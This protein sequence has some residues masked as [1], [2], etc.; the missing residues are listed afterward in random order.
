M[1][2]TEGVG[3]G[4]LKAGVQELKPGDVVMAS[5]AEAV[6]VRASQLGE[7]SLQYFAVFPEWL[8]GFLTAVEQ[9]SLKAAADS[10]RV[11]ARVLASDTPE[12]RQFAE[13]AAAGAAE[14]PLVR[15]CR[16]LEV[17]ARVLGEELSARPLPKTDEAGGTARFLRLVSRMPEA[18]LR[19]VSLAELA[20][21]CECSER[22]ISR[23][24]RN[25]FGRSV[26]ARQI[27]LRLQQAQ[28]LLR[29]TNAKVIDVALESGFGH[30]RLFNEKFKRQF[31]MTPSEWRAKSRQKPARRALRLTTTLV[32]IA[33]LLGLHGVAQT[34]RSAPSTSAPASKP[35]G[36][37]APT[38]E[39]RGYLVEGNTVLP[40]DIVDRILVTHVGPALTFD[41]IREGLAELQL[42]YRGRGYATI[43]VTLPRQ[44]L[45]N[46]IVKVKVVQGRLAEINVVGNRHFS[47]NNVLN[48]LPYLRTNM[49]LNSQVFQEELDRANAN[50]DR[51]IYPLI[52]PGPEAG[53]T[54]LT[55]KV[56]DRLPF[57]GRFELNNQSTPGTP[58]LR[59]NLSAQ[60]NNL[61]QEQHQI[62]VQYGF[63]PEEF[64]SV[65]A[66]PGRFYDH[67]LIANYSAF[68]RLP[69]SSGQARKE[70]AAFERGEF[71]YDEVTKKFRLPPATGQPELT[72]FVNRSTS[73]TGI[74][75]G[76]LT[77]AAS[78]PLVTIQSQPSGE[79]F[80][81]SD[82]LGAR[83]L[84][85]LK[86]VAGVRS[87]LSAGFDYKFF[88]LASFN[89]NTFFSTTVVTNNNQPTVIESSTFFA[90]PATYASVT[91]LPLS[92][93]WD[94]SRPDPL[95]STSLSLNESA[96][97][98][99]VFSD[100]QDFARL[101]GPAASGTFY[102]FNGS[103]SREFQYDGEWPVL[104]RA[105][106]QWANQPLI[107]NEQ[108]A[109]GGTPGVRGYRDGEEYGDSGWRVIVEPHTPS[110]EVGLV[111]G[112]QPMR[113]RG[114][115]FTDY[116]TIYLLNHPGPG[117]HINM[118]G[119]GAAVTAS[120]GPY[121][122]L[123]CTI[124]W[125]LLDTPKTPA[126]AMRIYFGIAGQF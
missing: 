57:H 85:P 91:Y 54:A 4:L 109:L 73:D 16:A 87:S 71:G 74:Q 26:R 68:Y 83:Y 97:F 12:A 51:Q 101:G 106:G 11:A 77:T 61:W 120:I 98:A 92:V 89:T 50:S 28:T 21:L 25:Y 29:E 105:E 31:G 43:A 88:R 118:W 116:G 107:S 47:S 52:G 55:L 81:W 18:G 24:F 3:Y 2:V 113:M 100:R 103:L 122:D 67:F 48:S 14:H 32:L 13:L 111:D 58:P 40:R 110:I 86:T 49:V 80:T 10:R 59:M 36:T 112:T 15:R 75:R 99:G 79:D 65:N 34:L 76:P 108:F 53:T 22:H 95:G 38:I 121:V 78:T 42:A 23:L 96:N 6:H 123:R 102:I 7:L 27:E 64:K 126:G 72:V 30:L 8:T 117:D 62:G 82:G 69:F 63:S 33:G 46:G 5:P 114:S 94:G 41:Q 17:A 119:T 115:I 60:Y 35:A 39:V 37:N 125:S 44:Q 19:Q 1:R 90:Q 66:L 9:R 56:K 124:A 104:I 45:T 93:H 84:Y 70:D 20:R